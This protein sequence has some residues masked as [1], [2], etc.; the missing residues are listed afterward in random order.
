MQ[1]KVKQ[2]EVGLLNVNERTKLCNL[3]KI[4]IFL[5][6][7]YFFMQHT[8]KETHSRQVKRSS[9][10]LIESDNRKSLMAQIKIKKHCHQSQE[11]VKAHEA[12]N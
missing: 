4:K 8:H 2:Q 12:G 7:H 6:C 11:L 9:F 10:N 1:K 3:A 5:L